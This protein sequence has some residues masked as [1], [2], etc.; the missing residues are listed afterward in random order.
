MMF[1]SSY[2]VNEDIDGTLQMSLQRFSLKQ[3]VRTQHICTN[4]QIRMHCRNYYTDKH[5]HHPKLKGNQHKKYI[6]LFILSQEYKEANE[7]TD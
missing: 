3:E 7:V 5:M 4:Y 1:A 2:I 6:V